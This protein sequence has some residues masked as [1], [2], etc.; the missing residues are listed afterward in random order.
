[1]TEKNNQ[2]KPYHTLEPTDKKMTHG[3][4][5]NITGY[6]FVRLTNLLQIKASLLHLCKKNH[7]LG[8]ILIAPEGINVNIS[9]TED[10]IHSVLEGFQEIS[11]LKDIVLKRSVSDDQPFNRMLVR[12]KKE[13]IAF[14]QEGLDPETKPAP[15]LS[16]QELKKWYDSKKDFVI[17][18][19]RNDYEVKIGTFENAIDPNITTFKQFVDF[20]KT[21]PSH[22]K[23]KP[24]V[25]F[26]TGGV[27]C[28]KAAPFMLKE[29]FKEVYQLEGGILKYFE[30][31]GGEHYTGDCF[32]FDKRVALSPNREPNGMT[33]CYC[34]RSPL[35]KEEVESPLY[36][37]SVS[38]PNCY[39]VKNTPPSQEETRS[40][41]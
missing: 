21:M 16:A 34:C 26:C 18:D 10:A 33:Q 13:I 20:V 4:I 36:Q 1:M 19:T 22:L 15:H 14:S 6:K 25:T 27:R 3:D 24:I 17:L 9:G 30:E 11:W 23:D 35:T 2:T 32:V 31:I 29:G 40:L 39:N 12:I 28:E 41:S 37:P 38:C 8:T 7:L 5:I